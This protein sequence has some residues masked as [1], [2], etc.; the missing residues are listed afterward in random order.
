MMSLILTFGVLYLIF[1]ARKTYQLLGTVLAA[2]DED[3]CRCFLLFS[4]VR[5]NFVMRFA[6]VLMLN[7]DEG[8]I[9][10]SLCLEIYAKPTIILM[11]FREISEFWFLKIKMFLNF[12]ASIT[13]VLNFF[14]IFMYSFLI[15][16]IK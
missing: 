15:K 11:E 3:S 14:L 9:F 8:S 1:H 10:H 5:Y 6:F 7:L 12:F 16:L 13:E 2:A 4:N